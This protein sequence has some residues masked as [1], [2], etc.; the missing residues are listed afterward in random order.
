MTAIDVVGLRFI[1]LH[2][3]A[4]L[5]ADV[6]DGGGQ[7]VAASRFGQLG[8]DLE[9]ADASRKPSEAGRQVAAAGADFERHVGGFELQRLQDPAVYLGRQHRLSMGQRNRR[10]GERHVARLRRNVILALN[11]PHGGQNAFV[12]HVPGMHLLFDH[13]LAGDF[14]V[15]PGAKGHRRGGK[16]YGL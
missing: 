13:L 6:V 15:H 7:Q 4:D 9:G 12:E 2:G 14:D 10:V 11:V 5:H 8:Q 3:V 16:G 1:E